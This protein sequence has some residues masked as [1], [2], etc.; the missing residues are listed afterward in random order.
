MQIAKDKCCNDLAI[1]CTLPE[2][3]LKLSKD[4]LTAFEANEKRYK[5]FQEI[6]WIKRIVMVSMAITRGIASEPWHLYLAIALVFFK[7][8][9]G[10]MCRTIVSNI[11]PATDL[12]PFVAAALYAEIYK[13]SL[14]T[15]PGRYCQSDV[16]CLSFQ[17]DL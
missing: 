15:F 6:N 13:A 8:V 10:P 11:I 2:N 3:Q 17:T 7:G 16:F 1:S 9:G 12:A 4:K 14:I 5:D